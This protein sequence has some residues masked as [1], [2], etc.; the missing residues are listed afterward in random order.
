MML[1]PTTPHTDFAKLK[2]SDT[3]EL[4]NGR[5]LKVGTIRK[6]SSL[7]GK[8][9]AARPTYPV[10]PQAVKKKAPGTGIRVANVAEL[11]NKLQASDDTTIEFPSGRTYTVAQLRFLQPFLEVQLGKKMNQPLHQQH[12]KGKVVQLKNTP[13][14]SYWKSIFTMADSTVLETPQGTRFTVGELKQFIG[15]GSMSRI[16][17]PTASGVMK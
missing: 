10:M 7:S 15:Q 12:H 16:S 5:R 11:S 2:D 14:R 3:V 6:F 8:L 9:K 17:T 13:D 1:M 4:Q